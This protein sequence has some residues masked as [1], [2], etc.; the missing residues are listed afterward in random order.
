VNLFTKLNFAIKIIIIILFGLTII[1]I[2]FIIFMKVSGSCY[3]SDTG[4]RCQTCEKA[5][6]FG[7]EDYDDNSIAPYLVCVL[8]MIIFIGIIIISALSIYFSGELEN[9]MKTYCNYEL[10]IDYTFQFF[11]I[12]TCFLVCIIILYCVEEIL[13]IYAIGFAIYKRN[14]LNNQNN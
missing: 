4:S 13:C 5:C 9:N 1:S 14:H 7:Y 8:F 11:G 12:S 2:G 6:S 3:D 10:D